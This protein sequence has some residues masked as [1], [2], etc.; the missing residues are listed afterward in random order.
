VKNLK[1]KNQKSSRARFLFGAAIGVA[2]S[3][4][5][6][7]DIGSPPVKAVLMLAFAGLMGASQVIGGRDTAGARKFTRWAMVGGIM[8]LMIGVVIFMLFT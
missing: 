8:S 6:F 3:V 7:S 2:I 5:I 1:G 4:P